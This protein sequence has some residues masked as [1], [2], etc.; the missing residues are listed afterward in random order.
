MVVLRKS[1][2]SEIH[3]EDEDEDEEPGEV[4]ESAPPLKIGEE[5]EIS[6]SGIKKKLLLYGIGRDTPNFG[7]EV[8]L[9]Y[10]S[11]RVGETE[12]DSSIAFEIPVTFK[13]GHG[14]IVKGLDIGVMTMKQGEVALF[15]LPSEM[16][17][18]DAAPGKVPADATVQFEVA[19]ISWITV[20]DICRDGGI[21]KRILEKGKSEKQPSELDEVLVKYE[22]KLDDGT[23]VAKTEDEGIEFY[24]KDG[25]LVPALAKAVKTM[26]MGEKTNLLVQSQYG[27]GNVGRESENVFPPVPPNSSLNI[28]LEL[29]SLKAVVDVCGDS[30]VI[31]KILEEG[32]GLVTADEGA[33]V[34][35]RYLAKL[36]DGTLFEKKGFDGETPLEFVTDEEQVI[37]GLDRAAVTMKKRERALLTISPQYGYGEMEIKKDLATVPPSSTLVYEIEMVDFVKEKAPWELSVGEKIETAGKLKEEGN[38]LYKSKK[39]QRA[40]KNEDVTFSD[41]EQKQ[42]KALRVQCWLNG[43]ACNL[44]LDNIQ[45][46][47]K[48]CSKVLDIEVNNVKALYRRAQAFMVN[49][50]LYLAELDIKKALEVDPENR[51]VKLIYKTLKQHQAE[52]NNRDAKFYENMFSQPAKLMHWIDANSAFVSWM[53]HTGG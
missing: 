24:V 48:L 3:Y 37:P 15:T 35:V 49:A 12:L 20:V 22:V 47:I 43:A 28:N 40:E 53:L 2:M 9:T 13:L 29:V 11:K 5:R 23:V 18:E 45:Q 10:M 51:E 31:K 1:D 34:T 42:V 21:V 30:M 36:E 8:T 38:I 33:A 44:K 19:L 7:D 26:K 41:D 17:Y 25:H 50:D 52:S 27:Y 46:V 4:I 39:Y 32:E 16:A 14:E 6:N